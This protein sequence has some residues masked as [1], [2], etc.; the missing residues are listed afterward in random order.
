[1]LLSR[2]D[3]ARQR[4]GYVPTLTA[5]GRARLTVLELCEGSHSLAEIERTLHER[6][7]DLFATSAE[8]AVFA[9]EVVTRYTR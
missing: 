1:M 9:A 6:H 2:D 5:R 3:L 8:A 7:R 4:A